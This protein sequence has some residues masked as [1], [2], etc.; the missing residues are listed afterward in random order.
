MNPHRQSRSRAGN[1][2]SR[3]HNHLW[4]SIVKWCIWDYMPCYT[5]ICHT[6]RQLQVRPYC[7]QCIVE[8]K[9][10]VPLSLRAGRQ[11]QLFMVALCETAGCTVNAF[12]VICHVITEFSRLYFC[13]ILQHHQQICCCSLYLTLQSCRWAVALGF[14]NSPQYCQFKCTSSS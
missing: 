4:E 11:V 6:L 13:L 2:S 1:P 3:R 8:A 9:E 10:E 5:N 12:T 14:L 7:L